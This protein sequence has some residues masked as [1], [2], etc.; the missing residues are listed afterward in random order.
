MT[1]FIKDDTDFSGNRMKKIPA[2]FKPIIHTFLLKSINTWYSITFLL[3][4]PTFSTLLKTKTQKLKCLKVFKM[5]TR[6]GPI[7]SEIAKVLNNH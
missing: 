6:S 4:I 1:R 3:K 5:V 7:F 2:F